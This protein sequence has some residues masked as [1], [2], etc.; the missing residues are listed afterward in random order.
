MNRKINTQ[1]NIRLVN[2]GRAQRSTGVER[3]VRGLEAERIEGG[4]G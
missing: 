3:E 1:V 4:L 2:N